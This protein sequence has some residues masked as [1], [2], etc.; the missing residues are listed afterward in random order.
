MARAAGVHV[1]WLAAGDGPMRP[2]D[3]PDELQYSAEPLEEE[4]MG[5][6]IEK[7]LEV[8][9]RDK[10]YLPPSDMRKLIFALY[11]AVREG[12]IERQDIESN[13]ILLKKFAS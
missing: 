6:I 3:R 11:N 7:T 9:E 5:Y 12:E 4:V 13:V 2:G 1:E 8:F 10:R